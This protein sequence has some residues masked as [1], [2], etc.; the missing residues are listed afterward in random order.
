MNFIMMFSKSRSTA[1]KTE[2]FC[3]TA[4]HC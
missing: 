4:E 3:K 1:M 2:A